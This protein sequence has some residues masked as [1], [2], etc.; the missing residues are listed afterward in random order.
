[1]HK[2][3]LLQA[4]SGIS[5]GFSLTELVIVIAIIAVLFAILVPAIAKARDSSNYVAC[6]SNLR[7]IGNA[8]QS[9]SNDNRDH[10][11]DAYSLGGAYF[12]RGPGE[13]NPTDP[14]SVPEIY[15]LPAL[16]LQGHYL[17]A[18]NALWICPAAP[19]TVKAYKNT[20]IWSLLWDSQDALTSVH[21]SRAKRA[22]VFLVYDNFTNTPYYTGI[23]RGKSDPNPVLAPSQYVLP[24]SYQVKVE[25]GKSNPNSRRGAINVLYI[26]GSIGVALYVTDPTRPAGAP[27][28][29]PLH[30]E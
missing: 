20:Y 13:R 24:H 19:E 6:K 5:G 25:Y 18:S 8:I 2:T 9:Y 16:L 30:G 17:T 21:R 29:I 10:I 3:G 11:P 15:G 1:M 23:R 26:N 27:K 14:T 12:R 7:Q 28:M 22:D 4:R